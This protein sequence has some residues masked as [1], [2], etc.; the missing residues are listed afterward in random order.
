MIDTKSDGIS[1]LA[2][3]AEQ[4]GRKTL[5]VLDLETYQP[6]YAIDL[7]I[8]AQSIESFDLNQDGFDEII[9]TDLDYLINVLDFSSGLLQLVTPSIQEKGQRGYF[10]LGQQG[11]LYEKA[12]AKLI[13]TYAYKGG[14]LI[15]VESGI[16][17]PASCD[18]SIGFLDFSEESVVCIMRTSKV[19][20]DGSYISFRL[21]DSSLNVKGSSVLEVE[22]EVSEWR[23]LDV[24][25][26]NKTIY[27]QHKE[28]VYEISPITGKI[29]STM[30]IGD[31]NLSDFKTN[32][33]EKQRKIAFSNGK[34]G[35]LLH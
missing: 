8:H 11:Y 3:V 5:H 32:F 33:L 15:S 4:F 12:G 17:H 13:N 16:E 6:L 9:F 35:Y 28:S 27:M 23:Y 24:N 19:F 2:Y 14:N 25:K 34:A 26:S 1:N 22:G 29:V 7:N 31:I 10:Y 18:T 30:F 20:D 21:L